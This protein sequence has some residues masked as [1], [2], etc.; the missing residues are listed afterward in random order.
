[1]FVDF[2]VTDLIIIVFQCYAYVSPQKITK[3][4]HVNAAFFW[5]NVTF[6]RISLDFISKKSIKCKNEQF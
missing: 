6:L 2:I 4:S 1:M 5:Q 3:I